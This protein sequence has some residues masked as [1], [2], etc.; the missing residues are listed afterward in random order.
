ML[1]TS[2]PIEWIFEEEEGPPKKRREIDINGVHLV[3]EESDSQ[4][5]EI[6]QIISTNPSHYLDD[7]YQPG[8]TLSL[9]PLL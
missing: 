8:R 3:V 2:I 7:K 1:Y 4:T 6:V 9:R 5:Y